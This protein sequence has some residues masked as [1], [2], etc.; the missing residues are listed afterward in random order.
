MKPLYEGKA[1]RLYETEQP[2]E[3]LTEFEDDATACHAMESDAEVLKRAED[4]VHS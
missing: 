2:D 3:L 4:A 1:K